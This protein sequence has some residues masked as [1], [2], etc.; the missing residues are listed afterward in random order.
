M[1][2]LGNQALVA[3]V[4]RT[5]LLED[6]DLK[7][8]KVQGEKLELLVLMDNLDNVENLVLQVLKEGPVLKDLKGHKVR[9]ALL[10]SVGRLDQEERLDLKDHKESQEEMVCTDIILMRS[11]HSWLHDLYCTLHDR[12]TM[13]DDFKKFCRSTWTGWTTG[14]ERR[15]WTTRTSRS[16]RR[17]WS[18]GRTWNR[19]HTWY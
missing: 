8:L 10:E 9:E 1:D 18:E 14:T 19:W 12:F 4:V 2:N 5:V 6:Q 15:T 16:A 7:G 11:I 3:S 17:T 13:A